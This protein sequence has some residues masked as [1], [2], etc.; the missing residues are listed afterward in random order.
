MWLVCHLWNDLALALRL[1]TS[2][3]E[4][5]ALTNLAALLTRDLSAVDPL[6][7]AQGV[8]DAELTGDQAPEWS[9]RL[10]AALHEQL[11]SWSRVAEL[12]GVSQTTA[13]RRAKPFM[14]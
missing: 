13:F 12:T 6:L 3:E 7:L 10:I 4:S 9:G 11:Q 8:K 5:R 14:Q 1:V 2:D